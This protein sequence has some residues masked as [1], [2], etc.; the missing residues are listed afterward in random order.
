MQ[1]FQ[2][3]ALYFD[4]EVAYAEGETDSDCMNDII[5]QVQN[6]PYSIMAEELEVHCIFPSGKK[7]VYTWHDA[8]LTFC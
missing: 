4:A 3:T 8:Q 1:D 5:E 6:S 2:I 7:S